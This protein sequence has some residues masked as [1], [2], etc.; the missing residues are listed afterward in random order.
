MGQLIVSTQLTLDGV[1]DDGI[2]SWFNRHGEHAWDR[3]AG[4]ASFDQLRTADALLLGRKTYEGLSGVWPDATD[5]VGFADLVNGMPKLV[6]SRSPLGSLIWNAQPLEGELTEAVRALKQ[7]PDGNLI[8]YGC[9]E[10]AHELLAAG[11]VDELRFW[12]NPIV[13]GPGARPF[14]DRVPVTLE[15]VS[16]TAYDTGIALLS[17]RPAG[18]AT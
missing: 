10:L 8:S 5:D 16:A 9:G 3:A 15:L 7:R 11:L 18:A 2:E 12:V 14:H 6:A 4:R 13:W 17:Y 1:Q